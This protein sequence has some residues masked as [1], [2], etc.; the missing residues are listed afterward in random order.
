MYCQN[1]RYWSKT[2]SEGMIVIKLDNQT[3]EI[4]TAVL[5]EAVMHSFPNNVSIIL[6]LLTSENMTIRDTTD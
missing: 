2:R 6:Q 3:S 4:L 5:N 1:N